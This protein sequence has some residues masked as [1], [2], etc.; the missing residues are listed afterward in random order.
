MDGGS[1]KGLPIANHL[2]LFA[3][4]S[5]QNP[6]SAIHTRDAEIAF[7]A[8]QTGILCVV[9]GDPFGGQGASG[10]SK[11]GGTTPLDVQ[12]IVSRM[13]GIV[14]PSWLIAELPSSEVLL[15]N[16]SALRS[17]VSM[18]KAGANAVMID[19]VVENLDAVS[20]LSERGISVAVSICVNADVQIH[21]NES[22]CNNLT[23]IKTFVSVGV[24]WIKHSSLSDRMFRQLLTN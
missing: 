17:A 21:L 22:N 3:T 19:G 4:T 23:L 16:T 15:G 6:I 9:V 1:F 14:G 5:P 24:Q 11:V 18:L 20:F 2:R 12:R 13:E 8:N 10:F 7:T